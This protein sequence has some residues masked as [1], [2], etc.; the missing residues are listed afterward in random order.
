[1]EHTSEMHKGHR[2]RLRTRVSN[3]GIDKMEYHEVLEFILTYCIPMKDVNPLAHTLIDKFGSFAGVL[4]A[5]YE[6]LRK[7]EGV[8]DRVALFLTSLPYIFDK[9]K[10]STLVAKPDLST[11]GKC[12]AHFKSITNIKRTEEFYVLCLD[13]KYRLLKT[14]KIG[15]GKAS[16]ISF[17]LSKFNESVSAVS[18]YSLIIMHTH[19]GASPYPSA[20][21]IATT[22][23]L[24]SMCYMMGIR[25]EDHIIVSEQQ[26]FTFSTGGLLASLKR[27]VVENL[28]DVTGV[29]YAKYA[30]DN[31]KFMQ[32]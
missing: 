27:E 23:R 18:P 10:A 2:E 9:Y 28:N 11:I 14:I 15:E 31:P 16:S 6:Y 25:V 13:S 17:E 29:S 30:K 1:M 19:P 26:Y 21:D 8:G 32:E 12:V 24:I 4:D 5:N 3:V 7:C 20:E 22:K